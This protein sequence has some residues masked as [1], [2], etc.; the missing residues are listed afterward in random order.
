[1]VQVDLPFVFGVGSF[2]AWA[3]RAQIAAGKVVH[4]YEAL[5]K[6]FAFQVLFAFW[7]PLYLLIN[8]FGFQ[9]SHMWWTEDSVAEY[10]LFLPIFFV[11][12][13]VCNWAGFAVGARLVRQGREK[14]SLGIFIAA[15]V[16]FIGWIALQPEHT[17]R[18]G[19]HSDWSAGLAPWI[20]ETPLLGTLIG[21]FVVFW[22]G[23]IWFYR[24]LRRPRV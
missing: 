13:F 17:L 22:I 19:S 14:W 5:L 24:D 3:A 18:D 15:W 6:N 10:P 20:H 1:M 23:L 16:F 12:Y 21:A 2:F 8:H 9:T 4:Y 7:L 11:L